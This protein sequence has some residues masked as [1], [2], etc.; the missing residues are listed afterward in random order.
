MNV[1]NLKSQ[2]PDAEC[3]MGERCRRDFVIR[4]SPFVVP[5]FTLIELLAVISIIGVLVAFTIP[6]LRG[7]KINQYRNNARAERD[8]LET[9]IERYKAAYGF[10]PPDNPCN[11]LVNQLYF[12]L[13]GTTVITN[14][15][16]QAYQSL[17]DPTI[18][19]PL[20]SINTVF[21]T[22]NGNNC[23]GGFMNCNKPGASEETRPAQNFL[24]GLKSTQ[25]AVFTNNVGNNIYPIKMLVTAVGGPDTIYNPLGQVSPP[26]YNPWRYNSSNPTNNPGAYDLWVQL[27]ISG[28]TNLICNWNKQ[29]QLDSPL[30]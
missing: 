2:M 11:P 4:H 22:V 10:Y 29:V 19:F 27:S 18:G 3:R 1:L 6:V 23:V 15:T 9:A 5:G 13:L 12:E 17:D 21:G 26:Y 7:I 14:S 25:V 30:P 28:R 20:T 16:G 8:Q 24:P